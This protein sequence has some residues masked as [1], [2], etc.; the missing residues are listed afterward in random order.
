M[1]VEIPVSGEINRFEKLL[2]VGEAGDDVELSEEGGCEGGG[3][4]A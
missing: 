2:T 1:R 3:G 4:T